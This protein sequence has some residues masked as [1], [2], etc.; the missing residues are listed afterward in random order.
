ML[1][2][3]PYEL[4]FNELTFNMRVLV[5][6]LNGTLAPKLAHALAAAGH[7]VVGWARQSVPPEDA[8]ASARWLKQSD[9][10]AIA[11][12][13]MGTAAWATQLATFAA[14]SALPF[15]FTSTAM[16]FDHL[17]DGPHAPLDERTAKDDYGRYKIGCEDAI[18]AVYAAATIARIGWQ[19]D[20]TARGNNMLMALN[21]SQ[22]RE[23]V[24]AAS[25]AWTPA[26][27]FMDDTAAALVSL[28]ESPRAGVHHLDSNAGE[29]HH[30]AAIVKAL[31]TQFNCPHWHIREHED[32]VHDQRLIGGEAAMP[33]LSRQLLALVD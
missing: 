11:H 19:I 9:V 2:A 15:I 21:D 12:L 25:R 17:P 20:A 6:G 23:G 28:L 18:R 29:G 26:C 33:P 14:Q 7:T 1:A 16:V 22:Q 4:P 3:A 8:Q 10:D 13:A 24:V 30:F 5:T 27:S 32:Y 31:R